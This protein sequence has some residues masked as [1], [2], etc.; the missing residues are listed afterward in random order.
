MRTLE[1]ATRIG[2][3]RRASPLHAAR[4]TIVAAY[5]SALALA[6][7]IVEDPVLLGA[8]LAAV[9]LAA[10]ASGLGRQLLGAARA[11]VVPIVLIAVLVNVL[12]S[13]Q[14]L[15]VFARLGEWGPL[16]QENL[17]VEAVV[18]GAVF[19]LRLLVVSLA[20]LLV[21]CA[22]DPDELLLAVRRVSPRSALTAAL[23]TRLLPV[24][25]ADARR[26][27]EAQRCRPDGAA[28]GA[29]ARLA[30]LRATVAGALDR[31]LD[32]AA[33][34]EMRGYG[35]SGR[36]RAHV[37]PAW[38]RHDLGFAAAAAAVLALALLARLGG[39]ASFHAYPFVSVG[40]GPV[41]FAAAGL[42]IAVAL[43]PLADRRGIE[44]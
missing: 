10:A 3:R 16:G 29:R 12:V 30:I 43:A 40:L 21:V 32:V 25:A 11:T 18:Y 24:L 5:G 17:T 19:A 36:T 20:C 13:R 2:Y 39:V 37:G 27:A 6:A 26:L 22:A 8:L 7:L 38:S 42:L 4:G 33:V 28:G 14:G 41:T 31:S 44:P 15:T 9:L 35:A 23:A 34:L 1:A